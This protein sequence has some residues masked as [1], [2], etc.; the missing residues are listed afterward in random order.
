MKGEIPQALESLGED[1]V[2]EFANEFDALT[3][4]VMALPTLVPEVLNAIESGGEEAVSIVEELITNPGGVVTVVESGVK[5]VFTDLRSQEST[6]QC[7]NRQL[8]VQNSQFVLL[9]DI[10]FHFDRASKCCCHGHRL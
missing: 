10:G 1:I 8:S 4:F 6:L 3:S 2:D 5:S 7:W 9:A